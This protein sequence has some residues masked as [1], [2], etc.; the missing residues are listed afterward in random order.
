MKKYIYLFAALSLVF[1]CSETKKEMNPVAAKVYTSSGDSIIEVRLSDLR[2]STIISLSQW[3]DSIEVVTLE[4]IEDAY[5]KYGKVSLSDH[6]ILVFGSSQSPALLFDRPT[7]KFISRV[8]D[9]G[10]GPGEYFAIYSAQIDEPNNRIY[11]LPWNLKQIYVYTLDGKTLDPIPT[12]YPMP[13]GT[14]KVD[15]D[16]KTVT[17]GVLPFE[18]GA[19][20]AVWKQDFEGNILTEVKAGH[21]LFKPDFSNEISS[22]FNTP[23]F[24]YYL[25]TWSGRPDSLYHYDTERGRLVPVFTLDTQSSVRT[26]EVSYQ[27]QINEDVVLK[28]YLELPHLFL[29][30]TSS[31]TR[32]EHGYTSTPPKWFF[33]DKATLSGAWF[34]LQNDFLGGY[35]VYPSFKNGYFIENCEP[36]NL[37]DTL[38]KILESKE[39]PTE[40]RVK[41]ESLRSKIDTEGNNIILIGKLK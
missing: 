37:F 5:F 25:L 33:V 22:T 36:Q 32:S 38:G 21:L 18:G 23:T 24:D 31:P 3:V 16:S 30:C 12:A 9:I 17:I 14:L 34:T 6:F 20:V 4:D 28:N 15:T 41:V 26:A 40:K 19:E 39:L 1:A 13:K 27:T 11:M 35:D 2:D 10:N 29:G 7:G 8:G